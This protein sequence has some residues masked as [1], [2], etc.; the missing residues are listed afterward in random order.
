[1]KLSSQTQAS[2]IARQSPTPIEI[3]A[4]TSTTAGRVRASVRGRRALASTA[5][6]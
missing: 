4:M 2:A 3:A 6:N 5:P 1:M